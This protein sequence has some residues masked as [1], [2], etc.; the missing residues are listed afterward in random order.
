M[1]EEGHLPEDPLQELL[2]LQEAIDRRLSLIEGAYA[3]TWQKYEES[4]AAYRAELAKYQQDL[5]A[6]VAGRR[7]AVAARASILVL[8]MYIAYRVT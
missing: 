2:R 3:E 4:N 7:F 8:L 1:A 6:H 5:P